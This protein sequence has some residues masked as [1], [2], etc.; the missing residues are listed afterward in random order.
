MVRGTGFPVNVVVMGASEAIIRLTRSDLGTLSVHSSTLMVIKSLQVVDARIDEVAID[1]TVAP[2]ASLGFKIKAI[3]HPL[4]AKNPINISVKGV[5]SL[6]ASKVFDELDLLCHLDQG[7]ITF[8]AIV[9]GS[10]ITC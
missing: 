7:Q 10:L 8:Q 1:F 5:I 6:S 4:V 3:D 2:S 9:I